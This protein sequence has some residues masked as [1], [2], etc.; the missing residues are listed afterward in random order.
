MQLSTLDAD[1]NASETPPSGGQGNMGIRLQVEA[2]AAA[3]RPLFEDYLCYLDGRDLA[4]LTIARYRQTVWH[5]LHTHST[6][7]PTHTDVETFV[8]GCAAT[9]TRIQSYIRWALRE[10]HYTTDPLL[11]VHPPRPK[12]GKPRPMSETD[13][14][15]AVHAAPPR[16]RCWLLLA[17]KAG[18]RCK[19]IAGIRREDLDLTATPPMLYVSNPK[20]SSYGHV[21]LH[22]DI[23]AALEAYG[24]PDSGYLF[25]GHKGR[26]FFHPS[27][28]STVANEYLKTLGITATMHQLRHRC[29]SRVY[30]ESGG[31]L[32][33]TQ[34][35][36]RHAS[37]QSTQIY[38]ERDVLLVA[39]FFD[40]I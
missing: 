8:N 11:R 35:V 33:L 12:R 2:L 19:E 10:G 30:D 4:P 1:A 17:G 13:F 24:L 6:R 7:Q 39:G 20:G 32:L 9:Y 15:R 38:A 28:L 18:L 25:R 22:P 36:L 21:P 27:R 37:V 29:G 16:I 14:D 5:W 3:A 40:R 34:R 31:D 23:V 26:A